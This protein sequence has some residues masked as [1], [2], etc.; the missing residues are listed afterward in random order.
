[1]SVAGAVLVIGCDL[2]SRTAAFDLSNPGAHSGGRRG[3]HRNVW[4][5]VVAATWFRRLA[6]TIF[7]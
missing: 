4:G 7:R 3:E 1:M 2:E 6:E 5:A